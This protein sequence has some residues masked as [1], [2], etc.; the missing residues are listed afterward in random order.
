MRWL[1]QLPL[2][3]DSDDQIVPAKIATA[4]LAL[5]SARNASIA[6]S[7]NPK[8]RAPKTVPRQHIIG[9]RYA[10]RGADVAR[11]IDQR[12][13]LIGFV[14]VNAVL[15]RAVTGMKIKGMPTFRTRARVWFDELAT[16]PRDRRPKASLDGC[17]FR[18]AC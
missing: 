3:A 1:T 5:A 11:G 8:C 16:G 7:W 9:D 10:D 15:G 2:A 13:D 4:R 6:G 17:H 14:A 12:Q 18:A